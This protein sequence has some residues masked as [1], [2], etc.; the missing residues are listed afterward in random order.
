[1][2][3]K[4]PQGQ[5]K[6]ESGNPAPPPDDYYSALTNLI[7]EAS[8][9]PALLR[10]LVYVLARHNLKAGTTQPTPTLEP[11]QLREL[12]R[13]I[14]HLKADLGEQGQ[15]PPDL[16]SGTDRPFDDRPFS[17]GVVPR[18]LEP[19]AWP[20]R[21]ERRYVSQVPARLNPNTALSVDFIEY[22]PVNRSQTRRSKFAP[23]V[24][25][26][27]A[28][29]LGLILYVGVSFWVERGQKYATVAAPAVRPPRPATGIA[30]T[31]VKD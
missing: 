30:G 23:V 20:E 22:A 11:A 27:A 29:V 24:Q 28:A 16:S 13:A 31:A 9:D 25:L 4:N 21:R 2:A 19:L 14:E 8:K 17:R 15:P 7:G 10:N 3:D 1:M 26:G 18:S 5:E 6:F 12:E